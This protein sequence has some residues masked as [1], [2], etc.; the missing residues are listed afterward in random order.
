M[1]SIIIRG[2]GVESE[3]EEREGRKGKACK[4]EMK[5]LDCSICQVLNLNPSWPAFISILLPCGVAVLLRS[6]I[7][8]I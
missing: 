4:M 3:G 1:I 2:E 5:K 7:S 8:V 6:G